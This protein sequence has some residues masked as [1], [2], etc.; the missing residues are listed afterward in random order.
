VRPAAAAGAAMD[1]GAGAGEVTAPIAEALQ[2]TSEPVNSSAPA[3][4]PAFMNLPRF[5]EGE[6]F[7]L[8]SECMV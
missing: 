1:A 4:S 7:W 5:G 2:P 8:K 3:E 6:T